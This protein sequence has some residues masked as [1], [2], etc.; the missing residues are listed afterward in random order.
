ME[1]RGRRGGSSY[2]GVAEPWPT[3]VFFRINSKG[4]KLVNND[5]RRGNPTKAVN[6]RQLR[7]TQPPLQLRRPEASRAA[8]DKNKSVRRGRRLRGAEM[9]FLLLARR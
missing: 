9:L 7:L 5:C 3:P 8:Y 4:Q 1:C 6:H 2:R